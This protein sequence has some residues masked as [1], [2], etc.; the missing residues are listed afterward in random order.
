MSF[1]YKHPRPAVTVD[2]IIFR[3]KSLDEILLVKRKYN[4]F[5][6]KWAFPGGYVDEN[7]SLEEAAHR[8]LKEETGLEKIK[9]EQFYAFGDPERDPRGHTVSIIYYGMILNK[10]TIKAGDDVSNVAWFN[11]NDIHDLAFDHKKILKFLLE[12]FKTKN[13]INY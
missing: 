13:G 4:P 6:N 8:E 11:I 2:I 9:L 10:I 3:S 1:N 5:K 7:E 12:K